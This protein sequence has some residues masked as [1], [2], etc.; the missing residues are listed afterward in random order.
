MS[1]PQDSTVSL[2]PPALRVTVSIGS[3]PPR[4]ASFTGPFRIGRTE[5]NDLCVPDGFVSRA[6]AEGRFVEGQWWLRDLG[7][8]NGLFV[9]GQRVEAVPVGEAKTVRLGVEGPILD[10]VV[11]RPVA[12]PPS[13]VVQ[14]SG[15]APPVGG[16]QTQVLAAYMDR[17]FTD[18]ADD[19]AG[20]HTR[21]VR[22]AF[23]KVHKKQKRKYTWM[24]AVLAVA[25]LGVGGYAL[26]LHQQASKNRAL[27]KDL[28]YSMKEVDIN[29]ANVEKLVSESGNGKGVSEIAKY[30]QRR[31]EMEKNYNNFINSL[32]VYNTK[33]SEQDRL[34][35]RVSRIF[36][37]C[38]L[39]MPPGFL[40]EVQNYIKKWQSSGRYARAVALAQ[41]KGYTRKITEEFLAQDLPPQFFYLAMQE[42][43]FNQYISGPMTRLGIAKGMWQFI[44]D[45]AVRYG[46]KVGPL[47]DLPRPDPSDDRHHWDLA[48]HAAARYIKDVYSTDAQASGLLVM[49]SYNWGEDRVIKLI[50]T[51][52]PN[53]RE[54]NFW[55]LLSQYRDKIPQ[56]TYDYVF[57]ITS[58]AVIGENPRL[59]GFDFDNPLGHLEAK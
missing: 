27:A 56:E 24:I 30:Q 39:D 59:F 11:E 38:E 8:S 18:T 26:Y 57:Y 15:S 48:T 33:L 5:E 25:M 43:D 53:P 3:A 7:S 9:D 23:Q 13:P 44:P 45:T 28:F 20:Q 36:G 52:P 37:E 35:L 21:M 46:L 40:E 32:K 47:V 12:P 54:R 2:A 29:I 6:H 42:S 51:M 4:T 22:L 31:R 17:Y 14:L 41:E 34:V 19:N 16:S 55:K 58:A 1:A 49:A 10:F 50:R